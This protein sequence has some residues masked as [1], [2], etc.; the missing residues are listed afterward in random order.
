M[1]HVYSLLVPAVEKVHNEL[2]Q[3]YITVAKDMKYGRN[4]KKIQA[5]KSMY[6][7]KTDAEL[8][9]ALKPHP[10]SIVLAQAALESSWGTSR[11]FRQ[12]NNIFGMHSI[13]P[14]EPRIP[15]GK[16][17]AGKRIVWMKKFKSIDDSVRSYYK[18]LATAKAYEEF[19][20][21]RVK[22]NNP[23][24]IVKE[25]DKYSEI[26]DRYAEELSAVIMHNNLT[27][28]D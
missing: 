22:T 5:L 28:Y 21:A 16:I 26:G 20:D 15:A 4:V 3:R 6:D 17:K 14:N 25:L 11:F 23:H 19:R 2:M 9:A 7:V 10:P 13:N 24:V 1:S 18:V 8:L 12:A 27:E